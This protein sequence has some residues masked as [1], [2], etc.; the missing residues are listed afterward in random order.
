[1][2]QCYI[3]LYRNTSCRHTGIFLIIFASPSGAKQADE[4]W[5]ALDRS[6]SMWLGAGENFVAVMVKADKKASSKVGGGHF[7]SNK[8]H[9]KGLNI[10]ALAHSHLASEPRNT[11]AHNAVSIPY[12][13]LIFDCPI[14]S[15]QPKKRPKMRFA[16]IAVLLTFAIPLAVGRGEHTGCYQYFR[17]KD[18]CVLAAQKEKDRCP[19]P[20]KVKGGAGL[21]VNQGNNPTAPKVHN[22]KLARRY[23]TENYSPKNMNG[24]GLCKPYD[25]NNDLGNPKAELWKDNA[26]FSR[27]ILRC[28]F[29]GKS[30][31]P[32]CFQLALTNKTFWQ[33]NPTEQEQR[34]KTIYGLTW[35]FSNLQGQ[36]PRNGPI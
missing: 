2:I 6:S 13:F 15:S 14:I 23:N 32:G 4:S 29:L 34:D 26:S 7:E 24:S 28:S 11:V 9:S 36:D 22:P 25:S 5:T 19:Y 33:L 1:M 18:G 16:A 8:G 17:T 21:F 35:D 10:L 20:K 27:L 12:R 30:N 31:W 3:V